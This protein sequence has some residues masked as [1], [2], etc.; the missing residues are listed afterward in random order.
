MYASVLVLATLKFLSEVV[1]CGKMIKATPKEEEEKEEEETGEDKLSG[2][3]AVYEAAEEET[4][5]NEGA[6]HGTSVEDINLAED[7]IQVA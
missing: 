4:V 5:V 6:R 7:A 2:V 3:E 1:Q